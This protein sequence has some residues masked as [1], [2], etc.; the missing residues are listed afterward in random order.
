MCPAGFYCSDANM[1]TNGTQCDSGYYCPEG[2]QNQTACQP[3][4]FC[5]MSK[6]S[7]VCPGGF[8]CPVYS[9]FPQPCPIGH[10]CPI[11]DRNGTEVGAI[12][13][14]LCPLGYKMYDASLQSTFEDTCE[15]CRPG[16]YGNHVDRLDC[17]PCRA[18]VVCKDRAT[19]DRPLANESEW[20][21][22]DA[23]RSYNCPA[24]YYC[25][26]NSSEPTPCPTGTFNR[27]E[28]SDSIMN[29]RRM[30]ILGDALCQNTK[31]LALGVQHLRVLCE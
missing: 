15:P 29:C 10:Y 6:T 3:G 2:S 27:L 28:A 30:Y 23:T 19:T 4:F 9:E 11:E 14:I 8:Y 1:T 31:P 17:R 5:N 16:Y 20:F 24:G 22:V 12:E 13:P 21:G 26:Q 18:G 7:E 25:P